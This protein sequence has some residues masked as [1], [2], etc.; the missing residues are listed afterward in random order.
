MG[1]MPIETPERALCERAL[2]G[3]KCLEFNP[4]DAGQGA[5]GETPSPYENGEGGAACEAATLVGDDERVA[6]RAG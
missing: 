5:P 1:L 4:R 2:V 3:P 6:R